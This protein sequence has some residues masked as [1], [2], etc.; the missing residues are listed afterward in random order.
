[1]RFS[2]V[3]SPIFEN[4]KHWNLAKLNCGQP[5]PSSFLIF[6]VRFTLN[7]FGGGG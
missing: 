4:L 6:P 5:K 2:F 1:M 7:F 3:S